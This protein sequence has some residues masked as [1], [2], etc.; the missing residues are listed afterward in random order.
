[1]DSN[2]RVWLRII[3]IPEGLALVKERCVGDVRQHIEMR[4]RLLELGYLGP[5]KMWKS[6]SAEPIAAYTP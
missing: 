5:P 3:R 4:Q 6:H 2:R 1:M